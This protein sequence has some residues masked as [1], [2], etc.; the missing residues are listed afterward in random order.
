MILFVAFYSIKICISLL[1]V[2]ARDPSFLYLSVPSVRSVARFLLLSS[3]SQ[4]TMLNYQF[5]QA[6]K[7]V[8]PLWQN[9]PFSRNIRQIFAFYS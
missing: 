8:L 3:N 2:F 6:G 1:C 9:S 5:G 7:P 4:Y